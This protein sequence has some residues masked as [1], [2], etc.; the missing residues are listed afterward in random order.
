MVTK[1]QEAYQRWYQRNSATYNESRKQKYAS[2]PE[3]R[4]AYLERQARYRKSNPRN[5]A[6]GQHFRKIK[7]AEVEVFRI[8]TVAEMI[9]RTEQII[10]IW[11]RDERIPKPTV[12][13]RH[14]Y[15]TQTQVKLMVEFADLLTQVRYDKKIREVAVPKKVLQIK[16]LWAGD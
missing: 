1:A 16:A 12:P 11:E 8:G 10:R 2:D 7:G 3:V 9:G 13:G 15:Y 6:S 4:Q 14:R 5:P